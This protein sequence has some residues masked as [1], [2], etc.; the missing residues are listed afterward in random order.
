MRGVFL[1]ALLGSAYTEPHLR[2]A[3]NPGSFSEIDASMRGLT[4]KVAHT[5]KALLP[6]PS[7]EKLPDGADGSKGPSKDK[8]PSTTEPGPDKDPS[9]MRPAPTD[10]EGDDGKKDPSAMKGSGSLKAPG[11]EL[12]MPVQTDGRPDCDNL[13]KVDAALKAERAAELDTNAEE[14]D[15][16]DEAKDLRV[17][18]DASTDK[19]EELKEKVRA[20]ERQERMDNA[21]VRK[22]EK[23]EVDL[24]AR[25]KKLAVKEETDALAAANLEKDKELKVDNLSREQ[26]DCYDEVEKDGDCSQ[27]TETKVGQA[28]REVSDIKVKDDLKLRDVITDREEEA[29]DAKKEAEIGDKKSTLFKD[30]KK[31]MQAAIELEDALI[32]EEG[33]ATER[34]RKV[35]AKVEEVKAVDARLVASKDKARETALELNNEAE[36][37]KADEE[38]QKLERKKAA[39]DAAAVAKEEEQKA[40]EASE[41]ARQDK[42][43]A[44]VAKKAE[45]HDEEEK[46]AKTAEDSAA[47]EEPVGGK[48][49]PNG[50]KVDG[51]EE[52]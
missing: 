23:K 7:D 5:A 39:V 26:I 41:A 36:V 2:D 3:L 52:E 1:L 16:D 17:A 31:H 25:D 29:D 37:R 8:E 46:K 42:R 32:T 44:A 21:E 45:E 27:K 12:P 24:D 40:A 48:D 35:A 9:T 30:K 43:D 11:A 22:L 28:F 15:L 49:V 6:G 14:K 10:G 38:K 50:D 4:A 18:V 20:D 33:E 47:A 34:K 19:V 13:G 51:D